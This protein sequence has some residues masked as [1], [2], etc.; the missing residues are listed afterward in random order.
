MPE[1]VTPTGLVYQPLLSGPRAADPLPTVGAVASRLIV[2]SDVTFESARSRTPCTLRVTAQSCRLRPCRTDRRCSEAAR[3]RT[4]TSRAT[5]TSVPVGRAAAAVARRR[6]ALQRA[7]APLAVAVRSSAPSARPTTRSRRLTAPSA[8]CPLRSRTRRPPARRRRARQPRGRAAA[9]RPSPRRQRERSPRAARPRS[10]RR[11]DSRVGAGCGFGRGRA[12]AAC[13]GRTVGGRC[14][15]RV[16]RTAAGAG[17]TTRTTRGA[18]G[19]TTTRRTGAVVV[20]AG[21]TGW[22]SERPDGTGSGRRGRDRRRTSA[23][24]GPASPPAQ[25]PGATH[26][27]GR[28]GHKPRDRVPQCLPCD[29]AHRHAPPTCDLPRFKRS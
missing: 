20:P 3:G 7:R 8:P 14:A 27:D 21:R 18:V 5:F 4:S 22:A 29:S 19:T 23:D 28:R 24:S 25:T 13:F 12:G 10:G 26:A 11:D 6:S 1:K 15:A 2:T 9:D 17:V 16:V